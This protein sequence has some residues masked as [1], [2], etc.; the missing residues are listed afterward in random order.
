MFRSI[1]LVALLATAGLAQPQPNV[2]AL[3]TY[4]TK[5][6]PLVIVGEG[7]SQKIILNNVDTEQAIGTLN[8]YTKDGQP[9]TVQLTGGSGS[10]F[11]VNIAPGG[12]QIFETVARQDTQVLGWALIDQT[13]QGLGDV[14]GQTVFRK[15]SPGRADLM[16]SMVLGDRG[17][18]E[19]SVHFDNTGGNYTG[20]GIVSSTA[21]T[22][23]SSSCQT[24]EL[25]IVT[26][27]D[28]NGAVISTKN[29]FQKRGRLNW[30]NLGDSFPETNGRAG[31]FNIKAGPSNLTYLTGFSLQ[32]AGNGAFTAITPY[33][34]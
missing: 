4:Y 12:T 28:L 24:D 8:F 19:F 27:K 32:F 5:V 14:L 26:I 13:T 1:A 20:L 29:L 21:C 16:T 10:T 23:L 6:V 15:Q 18:D 17:F 7:W 11:L 33:E 31:T 2:G 9:W 34:N 30:M 25:Y 22:T 3:T